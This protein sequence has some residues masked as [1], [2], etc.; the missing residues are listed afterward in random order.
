MVVFVAEVAAFARFRVISPCLRSGPGDRASQRLARGGER[1]A[2]R[3][4]A[5]GQQERCGG[6]APLVDGAHQH[7]QDRQPFPGP[8]V[9]PC[10]AVT[11]ELSLADLFLADRARRHPSGPPAGVLDCPLGQIEVE[12]PYRGQALAVTDPLHRDDGPLAISR[13][14]DLGFGPLALLPRLRDFS[15]QLQTVDAGVML[16]EVG[17]EPL[18]QVVS[19]HLQAG[20]IH[21]G[22]AF[23]QVVH[24]QIANGT[25]LQLV[26]VDEFLWREL[27]SGAESPQPVGRLL[28]ED[29]QL[30]Q[31]PVED[32]VITGRAGEGFGF[33]VHQ[34]QR[35]TNGDI[36]QDAALGGDDFSATP[37]RE[38]HGDVGHVGI[39]VTHCA[40]TGESLRVAGPFQVAGQGALAG[41]ACH[42][43]AQR[44]PDKIA[45]DRHDQRPRQLGSQPS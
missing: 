12:R 13:G 7:R 6:L 18:P 27:A 9:H 2:G 36:G 1:L 42:Q 29:S 31:H 5:S 37:Q 30:A 16:L 11:L 26:A 8:R 14:D 20:V 24:E 10:L 38:A 23:P 19:E 35:V 33:P 21:G 34:F 17:P 41:R 22:L 25:A 39:C 3:G 45:A 28:S 40:E 4:L 32:L 43:A 15:A 44:G